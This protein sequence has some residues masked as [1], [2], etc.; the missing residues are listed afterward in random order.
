MPRPSGRSRTARRRRSRG[1][2]RRSRNRARPRR[3]A[4]CPRARPAPPRRGGRAARPGSRPGSGRHGEV[5]EVAD[6]SAIARAAVRC[7]TAASGSPRQARSTP[8]VLSACA[9]GAG[10]DRARDRDRLLA[11]GARLAVAREQHLRLAPGGEHAGAGGR[12]R[13]GGHEPHGLLVG[14]GRG[15]A[16]AGRPQVATEPL[17]QLAGHL[18][19]VGLVER[20]ADQRG[21]ARALAGEVS[22]LGGAPQERAAGRAGRRRRRLDA[23]PYL[24]GAG[25]VGACLREAVAA[26]GGGRRPDRG[27]ERRLQLAGRVPVARELG[28]RRAVARREPGRAASASP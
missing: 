9:L 6:L 27:G 23:V 18:G 20:G 4:R 5:V 22:R 14:A 21:C 25:V 10:A 3:T 19:R 2:R 7:S 13:L 28:V 1:A 16:V 26:F 11:P 8:S 12:R 17:V 24:E 15:L